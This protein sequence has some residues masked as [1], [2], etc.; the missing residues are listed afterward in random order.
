MDANSKNSKSFAVDLVFIDDDTLF[1]STV[2]SIFEARG[3]V[4]DTYFSPQRFLNNLSQY[5]RNTK[6]FMDYNFQHKINGVKLAAKLYQ[7]GYEQLY[8]MSGVEFINEKVPSYLRVIL[9]TDTDKFLSM[10]G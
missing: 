3:K 8:L 6:I 1:L 4:V 2:K 7:A 10:V 5:S 9:K